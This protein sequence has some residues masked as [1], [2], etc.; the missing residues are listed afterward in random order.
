MFQSIID[1][2]V[3]RPVE[4]DQKRGEGG[5]VEFGECPFKVISSLMQRNACCTHRTHREVL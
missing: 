5:R 2:F 1:V 3:T 4:M